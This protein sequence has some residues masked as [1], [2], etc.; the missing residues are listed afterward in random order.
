[1]PY[2]DM[3]LVPIDSNGNLMMPAWG[4]I[5][6]PAAIRLEPGPSIANTDIWTQMPANTLPE[7][8]REMNNPQYISN[9][10]ASNPAGEHEFNLL[11]VAT[12][13]AIIR[14][15]PT[16]NAPACLGH[17]TPKIPTQ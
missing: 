14:L 12:H 2:T 3:A 10:N 7:L 9:F 15:N 8:E 13:T 4:I 17:A 5:T 1:M 6:S 16:E 11:G